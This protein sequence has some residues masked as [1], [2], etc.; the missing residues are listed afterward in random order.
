MESSQTATPH[1][2]QLVLLLSGRVRGGRTPLPRPLSGSLLGAAR[3]GYSSENPASPRPR[4]CS[5]AQA[6]DRGARSQSSGVGSGLLGAALS[7][8]LRGQSRLH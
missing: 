4:V 7:V 6:A 5:G 8:T 3:S 1:P 2:L